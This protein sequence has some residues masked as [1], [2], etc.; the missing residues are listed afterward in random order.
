MAVAREFHKYPHEVI[1]LPLE[2][3]SFNLLCLVLDNED[4]H[5]NEKEGY[6]KEVLQMVPK[7][8]DKVHLNEL[9]EYAKKLPTWGLSN[10]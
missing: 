4:T 3:W 1:E 9:S 7:M 10:G 2:A 8:K 6:S 5:P